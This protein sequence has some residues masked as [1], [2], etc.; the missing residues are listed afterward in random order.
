MPKSAALFLAFLA[1]A[2][3]A[4]VFWLSP[5]TWAA[6]SAI[7]WSQVWQKA[8]QAPAKLVPLMLYSLV[9]VVVIGARHVHT[10]RARLI[11]DE[12]ALRY[13]SGLPMVARWLD[14]TL[15]LD[16]VR[17]QALPLHPVIH[18]RGAHALRFYAVTWGSARSKGALGPQFRPASW[19]VPGQAEVRPAPFADFALWPSERSR[20][21]L[22]QRLLALPLVQAL[23]QQGI[24]LPPVGAKPPTIGIDLMAYARMRVAVYLFFGLL[25]L[26]VVL[27]LWMRNTYYFAT[28]PLSAWL[29]CAGIAGVCML[30]WLWGENAGADAGQAGGTVPAQPTGFRATQV[31]LAVLVGVAAGLCA[32]SLPLAW[33]SLTQASEEQAFALRTLPLELVPRGAHAMPS[34]QALK[35]SEY[36][37]SLPDGAVVSLPVRRGA[38]GLWWQFDASA[39]REKWIAYYDAHPQ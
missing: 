33:T 3:V 39:V 25:L 28:P 26:A 4:M 27:L 22:Q 2:A 17:S 35:A 13:R 8:E 11:L 23:A 32:P 12:H 14:W 21:V 1:L 30:G 18:P 38:L 19:Y 36:W 16:A 7:D 29:A 15:D 6:V 5:V 9:A 20:A 34:I 10:N 24:A 31:L 37:Q